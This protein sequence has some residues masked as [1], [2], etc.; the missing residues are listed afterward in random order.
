MKGVI[1]ALVPDV[2]LDD[3]SHEVAPGDVAGA[4]RTLARYWN[5]YP[6]G[7]VH[8]VV[9]DPGVGTE[10]RA[11][12][13]EAQGRLFVAPDNGALSRVMSGAGSWTAV[14]I[15]SRDLLPPGRSR[16]FH[17]RDVFAPAAAY[18][19]QGASLEVLG[20]PVTDPVR[21]STPVPVVEGTEASG[22]V[23]QVDRFG[24]LITNLPGALVRDASGVE[25]GDR[26][27]PTAG[28]YGDVEAG[29]ALALENSDGLLEV[30]VRNGS[31]AEVLGV[32]LGTRV[33]VRRP[34]GPQDP[35]PRDE[36]RGKE[37]G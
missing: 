20:P 19:A 1:A 12:A 8:L 17:G 35:N 32:G 34:P 36:G 23:I 7:T 11:L 2:V 15:T 14:E 25:V 22:E 16:T 9:V 18:L 30:A 3:V 4:A 37:G 31:A 28:T 6:E 21:I 13:L 10:R 33:T 29:Q 27:I 24:N 26:T 5:R